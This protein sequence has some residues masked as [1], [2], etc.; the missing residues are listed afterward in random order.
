[1]NTG[2]M[3][4][5]LILEDGTVFHGKSFGSSQGKSCEVGE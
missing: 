5:K 1:M 4:A 3:A 2:S